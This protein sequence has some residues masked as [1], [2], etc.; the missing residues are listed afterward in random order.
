M[1]HSSF[2]WA[3]QRIPPEYLNEL[4]Y[5]MYLYADCILKG[6]L[7]IT[8]STGF[9]CD[10]YE[11]KDAAMKEKKM[12][13]TVK[14]HIAVKYYPRYGV[15]VLITGRVTHGTAHDSPQYAYLMQR[16]YGPG[17]VFSDSGLTLASPFGL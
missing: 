7:Y 15:T 16:I 17:F 9:T 4:V 10:R 13:Q 2:G 14:L 3:M 12:K 6:G 11:I 1:D 5:D 8:D